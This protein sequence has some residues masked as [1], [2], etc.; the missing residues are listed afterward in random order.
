MHHYILPLPFSFGLLVSLSGKLSVTQWTGVVCHCL[1][2][3]RSDGIHCHCF[4][5]PSSILIL[6]VIFAILNFLR[7][8]RLRLILWTSLNGMEYI[9][10]WQKEVA[11]SLRCRF[12]AS[13]WLMGGNCAN[14]T[15]KTQAVWR[16]ITFF[17]SAFRI[18][19]PIFLITRDNLI[20]PEAM[21]YL[22]HDS[23][24]FE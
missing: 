22:V 20:Q 15:L 2:P 14:E 21:Q 24:L 7:F 9:K 13:L 4:V 18:G 8:G 10:R 17:L 11:N 6:V 3:K 16:R 12:T 23:S 19:S 5:L 1:F